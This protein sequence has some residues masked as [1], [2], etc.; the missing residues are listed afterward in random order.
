MKIIFECNEQ[1]ARDMLELKTQFDKAQIANE[2][3]STSAQEPEVETKKNPIG[4][5]T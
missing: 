2:V 4:F 3:I 1:E 5:A